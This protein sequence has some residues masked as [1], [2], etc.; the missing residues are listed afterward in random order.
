MKKIILAFLV[1]VIN[2]GAYSQST[3]GT[4][5]SN[6]DSISTTGINVPDGFIKKN[7]K[8]GMVKDGKFTTLKKDMKLTNGTV[9]MT[10]GNFKTNDSTIFDLKEGDHLDLN[11][12]LTTPDNSKSKNDPTNDRSNNSNDPSTNS[13]NDHLN[14]N[15][16]DNN[17]Q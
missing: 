8:I 1:L 3:Y 13:N 5:Q 9:V 10:N 14:N 7:G 15:K 12:K 2:F 11:G 4:A 6:S 17:N 16:N